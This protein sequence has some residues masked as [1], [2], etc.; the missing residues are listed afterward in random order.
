M[1]L[2]LAAWIG[3]FLVPRAV[4]GTTKPG[5]QEAARAI[6]FTAPDRAERLLADIGDWSGLGALYAR[7]VLGVTALGGKDN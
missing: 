2:L 1:R 4:A 5:P 7:A 6:E 3:F